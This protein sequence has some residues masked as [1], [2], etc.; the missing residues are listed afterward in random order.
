MTSM[1]PDEEETFDLS[2]ILKNRMLGLGF[3]Y[4]LIIEWLFDDDVR[5]GF[6]LYEWLSGKL[7][8]GKIEYAR[9]CSTV[10]LE[11]RLDQARHDVP[12]RGVPI[13]HIEAHGE[14][15]TSGQ[16]PR[17]F[18]GPDGNDGGELLAWE[19]LGDILRPLNVASRFNLL[20]VGAACY[21]EGLLLGAPGGKPMPF[22]AV[23]GYTDTV[24]QLS[25]RDSLLELYRSLLLDKSEL[26]LAVEAADRERHSPEDA[27]LR[28]TSM[29]VLLAESFIQGSAISVEKLRT[30]FPLESTES[31]QSGLASLSTAALQILRRGLA[32]AWSLMWMLKEFPEN[33]ERFAIDA[34][35]L[36]ELAV[37]YADRR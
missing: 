30:Q 6:S 10:E 20:V 25:L 11:A 37:E 7:P 34:D 29:V 4:V 16:T 22:V 3:D 27:V 18:V 15:P 13:V 17:G 21:G 31:P 33:A 32:E 26:G 12:M 1:D 35:R 14:A 24:S 2:D 23:V 5:T 19:R 28:P 36:I 8:A 9:C